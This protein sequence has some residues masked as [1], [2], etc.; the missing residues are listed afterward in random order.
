MK[1]NTGILLALT[2]LFAFALCACSNG[3]GNYSEKTITL[4]VVHAD[5]SEKSFQ[6][7]T[8]RENLQD[9]LLA[10]KLVEGSESAT[11]LFVTSVDGEA[12]NNSQQQWWCLT[13]GGETWLYGMKDT[14]IEDGDKFE[15]T[16][17]TGY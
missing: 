5:Q 17:T 7:K 10:E 8:D 4:K 9:A 12:A 16:L 14:K 2:L 13:K 1:K 11:G 3:S 6:I 15:F